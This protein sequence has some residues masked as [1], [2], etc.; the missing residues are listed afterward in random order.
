MSEEPARVMCPLQVKILLHVYAGANTPP[1]LS[2]AAEHY[3]AWSLA[4]GLME[5]VDR[6]RRT[7]RLLPRGEAL[8]RMILATPLPYPAFIDPRTGKMVRVG[9][10]EADEKNT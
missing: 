7:Y 9:W 5:P 1:E 6:E 10:C 8:V 4:E 2:P 3:I